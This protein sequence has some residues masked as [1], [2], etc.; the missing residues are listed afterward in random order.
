MLHSCID[1][2]RLI[3]FIL[4]PR[5]LNLCEMQS[6]LSRVWT[7]VDV[8]ISYDNNHYPIGTSIIYIYIYMYKNK[9][10][11]KKNNDLKK[12][13]KSKC[14][15]V[16]QQSN[17]KTKIVLFSSLVHTVTNS[18]MYFWKQKRW[19]NPQ[20]EVLPFHLRSLFSI[21]GSLYLCC[22]DFQDHYLASNIWEKH[23]N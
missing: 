7:C 10:W 23:R 11:I 4:I 22:L 14:L 19:Y 16:G 5:V 20:T 13:D 2:E 17:I 3:G 6:A 15:Y 21:L 8:S 12:L 9:R 1:E 18:F